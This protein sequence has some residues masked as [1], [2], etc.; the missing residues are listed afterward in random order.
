MVSVPVSA[1]PLISVLMA[2]SQQGETVSSC[3]PNSFRPCRLRPQFVHNGSVPFAAS[4][5]PPVQWVPGT[6]SLGVKRPGRE[7]DHSP[8]SCTEFKECLELTSTPQYAFM[9]LCSVKAQGQ[10]YLYLYLLP[11]PLVCYTE[12]CACHNGSFLT[13]LFGIH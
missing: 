5:Q 12:Y 10:L 1:S 4:T 8:P 3:S 9:A 6:L 13:V 7:A 2:F 11:V